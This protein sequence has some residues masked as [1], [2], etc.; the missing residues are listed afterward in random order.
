MYIISCFQ[1]GNK[2]W[3]YEC[4][5]TSARDCAYF[6]LGYVTE[7]VGRP[8][9][10]GGNSYDRLA[11]KF[12]IKFYRVDDLQECFHMDGY[13]SV[14]LSAIEQRTV[15]KMLYGKL[16]NKNWERRC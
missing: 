11:V 12:R 3:S 4:D 14:Y 8:P 1:S 6:C 15:R 16:F 7:R 9:I 13:L 5:E 10:K 2:V